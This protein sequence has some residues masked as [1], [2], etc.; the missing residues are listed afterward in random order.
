ME[1]PSVT[2]AQNGSNNNYFAPAT[3]PEKVGVE[4][5]EQKWGAIWEDA[6][7]FA[8]DRSVAKECVYSIDRKST[9][10]NSSHT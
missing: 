3:T 9:R 1:T 7:T 8:F 5:L 6:G 2:T 10:L 4:G